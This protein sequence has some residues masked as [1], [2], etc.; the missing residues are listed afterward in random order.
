[1]TTTEAASASAISRRAAP[2]LTANGFSHSTGTPRRTKYSASCTW[3]FGG[4]QRNTPSSSALAVSASTSAKL[5]QPRVA[6]AV[7]AATG[8]RIDDADDDGLVEIAE[9]LHVGL[10]DAAGADE[11]EPQRRAHAPSPP[12]WRTASTMRSPSAS[13]SSWVY[14]SFHGSTSTRSSA[15]RAGET[16]GR[17]VDGF[18]TRE[19]E[20][21]AARAE[22]LLVD[23]HAAAERRLLDVARR[24][25]DATQL[26]LG[27]ERARPTGHDR[28]DRRSARS[29]SSCARRR[30]RAAGP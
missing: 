3:V 17:V 19:R 14:R 7:C 12:T 4:V 24:R 30:G 27:R 21:P 25:R 8:L 26:E 9:H 22:R 1:M 16:L 20:R 29:A 5:R 6:A 13:T 23:E 28:R 18:R 2:G 15:E 10:R 11:P